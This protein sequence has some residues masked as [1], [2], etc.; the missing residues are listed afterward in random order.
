MRA[1]MI[2]RTM[3]TMTVTCLVADTEAGEL[4][5]KAVELGRVIDDTKKLEKAVRKA[6]ET[7]TIKFVSIVDTKKNTAIYGMSEDDFI[8]YASLLDENR[9]VIPVS[10]DADEE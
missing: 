8:K 3:N 2:T 4:L 5:N 10:V 1:P 6:V 7:D 9:K